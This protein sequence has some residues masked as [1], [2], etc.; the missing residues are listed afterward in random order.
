MKGS[1]NDMV[2]EYL[3]VVVDYSRDSLIPEQLCGGLIDKYGED[4]YNS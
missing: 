1:H 4:E 2:K 3:G